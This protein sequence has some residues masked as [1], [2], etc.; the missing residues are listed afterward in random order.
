MEKLFTEN[1]VCCFVI[2][3]T[4]YISSIVVRLLAEKNIKVFQSN[5]DNIQKIDNLNQHAYSKYKFFEKK[6]FENLL[7]IKKNCIKKS[8][9]EY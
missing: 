9:N 5:W 6:I 8:R 4:T 3:D 2:S 1:K 7:I